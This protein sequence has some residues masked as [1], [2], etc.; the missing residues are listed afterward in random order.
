MQ[1]VLDRS[2]TQL[3]ALD[4]D[5]VVG[6]CDVVRRNGQGFEHAGIL[7]MGLLP[8]Y[9]SMGLGHRMLEA[10]LVRAREAGIERIELS[11]WGSNE[12]ARK[13]YE[14]SGFETEGVQRKARVLDGITDDVVLMTKLKG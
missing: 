6:W 10:A 8:E 11:V 3:V 4:G 5:R 13:L 9:R 14:R 7:G 1:R 2:D 12:P